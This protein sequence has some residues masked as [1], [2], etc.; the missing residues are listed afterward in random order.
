MALKRGG[1]HYVVDIKS[2]NI[3]VSLGSATFSC[4]D[5]KRGKKRDTQRK[6][7]PYHNKAGSKKELF[8]F[9]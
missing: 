3:S 5:A 8:L 6:I 9:I 4:C 1:F 7:Q 2:Q